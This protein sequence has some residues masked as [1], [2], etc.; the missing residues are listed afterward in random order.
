MSSSFSDP[1]TN[2]FN[3]YMGNTN[4]KVNGLFTYKIFVLF[5]L[6]KNALNMGKYSSIINFHI[7]ITHN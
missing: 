7:P 1:K 4:G 5:N 6:E 3:P 2:T